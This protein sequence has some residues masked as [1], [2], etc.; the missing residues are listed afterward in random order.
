M[1][2]INVHSANIL[3]VDDTPE[4]LRLLFRALFGAGH[5]V[6]AAPSGAEALR[7]ARN[8]PPDII[9]LDIDMPEMNGFQVCEELQNDPVLGRIP[10]LFISAMDDTASKLHAFVRGGR[11][12]VTKPFNVEEVLA[13]VATHV[14]LRRLEV[15]LSAQKF[16]LE[17][18]VAAQVQEI[19]EAQVA[20]IVALAKLS[21]S[22][23]DQTGMHVERIGRLSDVLIRIA[24]RLSNHSEEYDDGLLRVIGRAATLHDIG[25]VGI[26][27]AILLKPGKLSTEEFET[28]KTHSVVGANTLDLV[29]ESY[30]RNDLVRVG[31]EIARGHHEKWDGNGYPAGLAGEA[32]PLSARIV[33]LVD[34]YDAIRCAR[35][36]KP[37]QPH[38][39]AAEAVRKG[40]GTHF[41]PALVEAFNVAEQE[42]EAL[43]IALQSKP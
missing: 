4:N 12:F 43:W 9:L 38:S 7:L 29:L 31:A 34:V 36:Y 37:E 32:I 23:D 33:A 19:S 22:R 6:R 16:E 5:R 20:T 41:D 1:R 27:D 17:K 15:A 42:I 21:E 35:P 2:T 26:P 25:K 10:V 24:K 11:D 30:P 14:E 40:S 8:E 28:M 3:V 39:V 13:R 18:V